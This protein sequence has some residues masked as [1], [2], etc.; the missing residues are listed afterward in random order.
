M[1]EL[2]YILQTIWNSR[3]PTI[4]NT[5]DVMRCLSIC[6]CLFSDYK[7]LESRIC[8]SVFCTHCRPR[9][10]RPRT[11]HVVT[12][13]Y[14][15]ENLFLPLIL[16]WVEAWVRNMA[17]SYGFFHFALK[18]ILGMKDLSCIYNSWHGQQSVT[19]I[20]LLSINGLSAV[21]RSSILLAHSSLSTAVW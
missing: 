6:I 15:S 18:S 3:E 8:M 5:P 14:W 9:T 4:I 11:G 21:T 10:G 1:L 12:T 16:G 17:K 2:Y 7:Q 19:Y 13:S 20:F